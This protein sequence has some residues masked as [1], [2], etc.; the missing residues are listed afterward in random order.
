MT[1]IM[2]VIG[3]QNKRKLLNKIWPMIKMNSVTYY[4]NWFIFHALQLLLCVLATVVLFCVFVCCYFVCR[5]LHK[6]LF[7]FFSCLTTIEQWTKKKHW[8]WRNNENG[9]T[10]VFSPPVRKQETEISHHI[11]T[12]CT[13]AATVCVHMCVYTPYAVTYAFSTQRW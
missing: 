4:D 9:K 2:I 10:T 6:L 11:Y 13:C 3:M 7:A 12:C 1:T 8:Y 5:F